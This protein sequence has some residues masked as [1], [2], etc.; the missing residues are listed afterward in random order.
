VVV[1]ILATSASRNGRGRL[2]ALALFLVGGAIAVVVGQSSSDAKMQSQLKQLFPSATAFS[3]KEGQ[4]PHF[5][6]YLADAV[7]RSRTLGG[8]AFWTTDLEPLERGYDG[9]IKILVGMDTKGIIT[10]VIVTDHHEPYGNFSIDLPQFAAQFKGKSIRDPFKVG[11]DI[12]AVS[13]ASISIA[14]ATRAIR[15]GARRMARQLP[16]PD[17]R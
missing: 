16:L 6:A 15:N 11:A 5:S 7:S 1:A 17:A 13:R 3:P 4:P 9:P 8:V 14:S 2:E 10:G 12:D